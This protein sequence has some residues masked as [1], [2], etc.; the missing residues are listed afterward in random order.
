M[1]NYAELRVSSQYQMQVFEEQREQD[2]AKRQAE[3]RK[4]SEEELLS[5]RTRLMVPEELVDDFSRQPEVAS[6]DKVLETRVT[7][8]GVESTELASALSMRGGPGSESASPSQSNSFLFEGNTDGASAA[9][10]LRGAKILV[11]GSF[12]T[13]QD[14]LQAN[15]VVLVEKT[16][17]EENGLQ[18]GDTITAKITGAEGRGSEMELTVKGIYE[19]VEVGQE[20]ATRDPMAFNPAGSKFYVPLSVLQALNNTP[21]RGARLLLPGQRGQ[22]LRGAEIFPGNGIR[23]LGGREQVRAGH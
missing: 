15:P 3:A 4:M 16:L 2:P 11:E 18:V 23:C 13:Y 20:G 6:Y 5:E 7:L 14:Y 1:G 9:D 21:G 8:P 22:L 12:Y 10:F 17:A 19:T